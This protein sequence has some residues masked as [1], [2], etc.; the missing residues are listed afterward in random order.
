M[1]HKSYQ[2]IF[3]EFLRMCPYVRNEVV[4]W[5]RGEDYEII[6]ELEDGS[7]YRYDSLNKT[8]RWAPSSREFTRKPRDEDEWKYRFAR[9]LYKKMRQRGYTQDDLSYETKISAG[10]ISRYINGDAVPTAYKLS[11]IAEVLHC[12]TDDLVMFD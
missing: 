10:T 3:R 2:A 8:F 11:R 7:A 12:S 5:R 6:A 1:E 4:S 9:R